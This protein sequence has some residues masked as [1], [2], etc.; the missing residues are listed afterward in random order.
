MTRA[1]GWRV[2][3]G[4]LAGARRVDSPN[5]DE[6][7]PGTD[8]DLLVVHNISLPPG[9]FGGDAIER[10]FTN[11]IERPDSPFLAN[12]AGVRVSAHFLIDRAG[13]VTQF[14]SIERRAWHAG[15]SKF[16]G[17]S[18]CN[19][20]SVGVELEGS[21]FVPFA[22]VQYA[23]LGRLTDALFAALPL[24]AIRGHAHI[25]PDRKTDP[26]PHF[27]WSA[28]RACCLVDPSAFPPIGG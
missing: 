12:L 16:A 27:D 23:V 11:R 3:D 21:D 10:L 8:V 6:R 14:V 17:R 9:R 15:A 25:A 18:G 19:A 24:R 28:L 20:F 2:R 22:P 1:V 4:W 13:A 26:G 5:A 7:P